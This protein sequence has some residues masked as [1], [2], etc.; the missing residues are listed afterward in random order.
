DQ[1]G[2]PEEMPAGAD[3]KLPFPAEYRMGGQEFVRT[4]VRLTTNTR[5]RL[6]AVAERI[7]LGGSETV[8]DALNAWFDDQGI[9]GEYDRDLLRERPKVYATSARLDDATRERVK[10]AAKQTGK[11]LQEVWEAAINSYAGRHGV[12]KQMPEGS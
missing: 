2:I 3:L 9:P 1:I 8:V 10:A 7:G 6:V 4:T 11:S 5:A 12:P